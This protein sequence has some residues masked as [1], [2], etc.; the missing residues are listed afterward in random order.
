MGVRGGENEPWIVA[1]NETADLAGEEDHF[2]TVGFEYDLAVLPELKVESRF[3]EK[4]GN[5]PFITWQLNIQNQS[6]RPLEI[7]ELAFPFALNNF[8]EGFKRTEEDLLRL[9]QSRVAVHKFIGGAGSY[10]LAQRLSGAGPGLLIFPGKDTSWEFYHHVPASLKTPYQWEGIPIVYVHSKAAVEREGWPNW[11]NG[12]SSRILRPGETAAFET[13]FAVCDTGS[14]DT[15]S[16]ALVAAGKPAFR[17]FPAAVAPKNVG[18]SLEVAARGPV[19]FDAG[20]GVEI[21]TDTDESGGYALIKP[22]FAGETMVDIKVSGEPAS[23]AHLFFTEDIEVLIKKRAACIAQ[24]QTDS[25]G[26]ILLANNKTAMPV[27]D[28][29][30][31]YSAGLADALFLAEKNTIYP[32]PGEIEAL[33]KYVN[34]LLGSLQNPGDF[35]VAASMIDSELAVHFGEPSAYA[36]AANLY[37]AMSRIANTSAGTEKT[38]REYLRLAYGTSMAQFSNARRSFSD[39]GPLQPLLGL[40]ELG[41]ELREADMLEEADELS[42]LLEEETDAFRDL[43]MPFFSE[44][45]CDPDAYSESLFAST[46]ANLREQQPE[47][48]QQAFALRSLAPSW[49]WYGSDKKY[50][51]AMESEPNRLFGDHGETCLEPSSIINSVMFFALLD[52]DYSQLPEAYLRLAFGGMLGPW[53]LVNEDGSASMCYCPD[54]ASKHY[55]RNAFSGELGLGLFR[56]LRSVASFVLPGREGGLH[57][58]GCTYELTDCAHQVIPWDG[59]GRRIIIRQFNAEFE[60]K[61]GNIRELRLAKDKR[62]FEASISNPSSLEVL[63]RLNVQGMWGS[64][65]EC[66][67]EYYESV[68]GIISLPISL[69]PN[70]VIRVRA[71]VPEWRFSSGSTSRS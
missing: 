48:L 38:A 19:E 13:C 16:R 58:F 12:H 61:F 6:I 71:D 7:G 41:A 45:V 32:E 67:G 51:D 17:L 24:H 31:S 9:T 56:Y 53:A 26:A 3:S 36:A 30:N 11:A 62:W 18:I 39:S 28:G 49:W 15:L 33:N 20:T 8:L 29:P 68:D 14:I 34:F 46:Y 23:R 40:S 52:T 43:R 59:V 55:G 70:E 57:T 2:S 27:A 60:L 54:V 4:K 22:T 63:T 37:L 35:S 5:F 44:I 42:E 10:L 64:S 50:W 25:R 65:L 47:L 66:C 21:E 69:P 1:R